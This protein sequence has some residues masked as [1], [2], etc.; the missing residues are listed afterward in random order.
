M[1]EKFRTGSIDAAFDAGKAV[2]PAVVY[3]SQPIGLGYGVEA[4]GLRQTALICGKPTVAAVLLC[5][6]LLP[7]DFA[8][9]DA[10]AKAATAALVDGYARLERRYSAW[11]RE[12]VNVQLPPYA[13]RAK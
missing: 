9:A 2:Q 7:K 8:T 13:P 6:V 10:M 1:T 4:S 11:P 12:D 3:Y 5:P